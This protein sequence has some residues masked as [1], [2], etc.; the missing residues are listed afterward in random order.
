MRWPSQEACSSSIT[1]MLRGR[2]G[3]TGRQYGLAFPFGTSPRL[4]LP[5][6]ALVPGTSLFGG[7]CVG[8]DGGVASP[9]SAHSY[10]FFMAKEEFWSRF[11]VSSFDLNKRLCH[12]GLWFNDVNH[13]GSHLAVAPPHLG[14]AS[15]I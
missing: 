11:P 10:P 9:N 8:G 7:D 3:Q 2:V 15:L 12:L 6:Y 14:G 13:G 1:T 5:V 4:R